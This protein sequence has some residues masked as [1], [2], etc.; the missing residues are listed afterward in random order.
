MLQNTDLKA[1]VYSDRNRVQK[2]KLVYR[3]LEKW[4]E[5]YLSSVEG[6][7]V[8]A[9]FDREIDEHQRLTDLK[10]VDFVLWQTGR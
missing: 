10:K 1:P 5:K 2:A 4:Y 9:L 6:Q 7:R 3:N 8:V